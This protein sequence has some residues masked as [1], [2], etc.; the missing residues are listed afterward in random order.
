[1]G[2]LSKVDTPEASV[3]QKRSF[4]DAFIGVGMAA[5]KVNMKMKDT[6]LYANSSGNK[7]LAYRLLLGQDDE[8]YL[9]IGMLPALDGTQ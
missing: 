9:Q 8:Q 6:D 3:A 2:S 4:V 7:V 5:R 1:M